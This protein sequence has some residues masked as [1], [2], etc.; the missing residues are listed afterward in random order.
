MLRSSDTN[1]FQ[2]K[3]RNKIKQDLRMEVLKIFNVIA[4]ILSV[5]IC[6]LDRNTTTFEKWMKKN[7]QKTRCLYCNA[8]LVKVSSARHCFNLEKYRKIVIVTI[9]KI[10]YLDM[11][12]Q[13]KNNWIIMT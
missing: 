8:I 13:T 10:E 6:V 3:K 5:M 11:N 2:K 7:P 1:I 4:N 9:T 12:N